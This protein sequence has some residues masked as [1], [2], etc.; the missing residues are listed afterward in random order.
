MLEDAS[1]FHERFFRGEPQANPL[2]E[3]MAMITR[4]APDYFD[5][6]VVTLLQCSM[7]RFVTSNLLEQRPEFKTMPITK[8][9]VKFPYYFR[10]M[11]GLDICYAVLCFPK[12]SH[13]DI[14]QYLE[15]IPD[16]A[17]FINISNDVLS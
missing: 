11:A 8:S 12:D 13:P 9:G 2:L 15:A 6:M 10:D 1:A 7:L 4:E 5:P 3:G 16:M 17:V 14:G